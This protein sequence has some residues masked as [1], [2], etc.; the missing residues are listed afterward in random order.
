MCFSTVWQLYLRGTGSSCVWHKERWEWSRWRS[1]RFPWRP[2]WW[3]WGDKP[4]HVLPTIT[5][6]PPHCRFTPPTHLG[7]TAMTKSS[8]G[9]RPRPGEG[10]RKADTAVNETQ[11]N[12]PA[13]LSSSSSSSLYLW[14]RQTLPGSSVSSAPSQSCVASWRATSS[15]PES[16]AQTAA[17]PEEDRRWRRDDPQTQQQVEDW[18]QKEKVWF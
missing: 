14:G 2:S 9:P 17:R 18:W 11:S 1:P 16:R 10:Q 8:V 5:R 12:A 3:C 13:G 4:E 6:H 15:S 7:L